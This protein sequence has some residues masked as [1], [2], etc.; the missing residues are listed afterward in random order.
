MR[1]YSVCLKSNKLVLTLLTGKQS[2]EQDKKSLV[3]R[4]KE[5]GKKK[6]KL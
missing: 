6:M 3:Y 1:E 4:D 5:W 2:W